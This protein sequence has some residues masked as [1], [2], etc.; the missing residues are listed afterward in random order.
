[1]ELFP[2]AEAVAASL[3]G[4]DIKNTPGWSVEVKARRGFDPVAALRQAQSNAG[5]TEIPVVVIRPN[6]VGEANIRKWIVCMYL[7]DFEYL[8]E[9]IQ[10]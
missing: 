1:M 8:A 2:E 9:A 4:K 7:D 3:P 6:G 5:W 10:R